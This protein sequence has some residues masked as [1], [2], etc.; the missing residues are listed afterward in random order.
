[1]RLTVLAFFTALPAVGV[2]S[3]VH[4][5]AS[6]RSQC[7]LRPTFPSRNAPV[8]RILLAVNVLAGVISAVYLRIRF[9]D[10]MERFVERRN[11]SVSRWV[12][13]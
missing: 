10:I 8:P 5:T 12:L 11:C 9:L 13:G 2:R 7:R 6:D 3:S 1:M 4:P